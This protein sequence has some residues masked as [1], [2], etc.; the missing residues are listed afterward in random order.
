MRALCLG[1]VLLLAGCG[2]RSEGSGGA[3]IAGPDAGPAPG[4]DVGPAPA[5][6][7]HDASVTVRGAGHVL[8]DQPTIGCPSACGAS[9]AEGTRLTLTARP[10]S[11]AVFAGWTGACSGMGPCVVEMSRDVTVGATFTG[12]AT[13]CRGL[14]PRAPEPAPFRAAVEM[15]GGCRAGTSDGS[16]TVAL[17]A[18]ASEV[19]FVAMLIDAQGNAKGVIGYALLFPQLSGFVGGV[20]TPRGESWFVHWSPDGILTAITTPQKGFARAGENPLGGVVAYVQADTPFA[21]GYDDELRLL[22]RVNLPRGRPEIAIAADRAG[23]TLVLFDGAARKTLEGVWID[24]DGQASEVFQV[25]GLELDLP[26]TPLSLSQRVGGG[27]FLRMEGSWIGEI[28]SF[29]ARM[30]PAPDWL[31]ARSWNTLPVVH[32]GAAYAV[33]PLVTRGHRCTDSIEVVAPSGTGCG[34]ADFVAK[35]GPCTPP[36]VSVGYDGTV[37]QHVPNTPPSRCDKP[38]CTCESHWW[39]GFFR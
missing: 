2:T 28:D 13:E 3:Q 18:L 23:A 22:W 1:A 15:D 14:E 16:G 20:D 4:P 21:V 35:E 17:A 8:S 25:L 29:S 10:E 37:V 5:P 19:D 39:P 36:G 11:G 30:N 9:L 34:V 38:P 31:R 6:V 26:H 33:L 24:R 27:F 7:W 12:S 32:G